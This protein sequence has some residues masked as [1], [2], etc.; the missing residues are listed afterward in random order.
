MMVGGQILTAGYRADLCG[1]IVVHGSEMHDQ[2]AMWA[3]VIQETTDAQKERNNVVGK[4]ATA[5]WARKAS[6]NDRVGDLEDEEDEEKEEE[7][8]EKEEE[9][10]GT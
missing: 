7:E 8:D 4:R 1:L 10:E 3:S 9:E 6:K 5:R 2:G